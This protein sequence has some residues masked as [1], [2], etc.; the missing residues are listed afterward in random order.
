LPLGIKASTADSLRQK[1]LSLCPTHGVGRQSSHSA[2]VPA[3][4]A[5]IR[6]PHQS[7]YFQER[8]LRI[9]KRVLSTLNPALNEV[10]VRRDTD[11]LFEGR[12]VKCSAI[13]FGN[14]KRDYKC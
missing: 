6:E 8:T 4:M 3:Q 1:S 5:L 11:T 2:E 12:R 14:R 9:S 10:A 7:S 13:P